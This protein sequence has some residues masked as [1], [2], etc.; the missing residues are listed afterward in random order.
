MWKSLIAS[1]AAVGVG[2]GL[3]AGQTP[4]CPDPSFPAIG[5][6]A[7]S[8]PP[9]AQPQPVDTK[10]A[11]E[12]PRSDP[13]GFNHAIF[14]TGP[15]PVVSQA[16]GQMAEPAPPPVPAAPSPFAPLPGLSTEEYV[17]G[18]S[19]LARPGTGRP[20]VWGSA[21]LLLGNTSGVNVAPVVT[22]GIPFS[23][24]GGGAMLGGLGT[25]PVFGGKKMLDN[26]RTGLKT[27]V[28]AWFDPGHIWGASARFYS[29]Y[30]TSDQF[31]AI[32]DGWTIINLPQRITVVTVGGTIYQFPIYVSSPALVPGD[33]PVTGAAA[34]T[35][36][37]TFTGGDLNLRRLILSN[38]QFRVELF[39]GY[40]QMH[41]GDELGAAFISR[42][43]PAAGFLT[44]EGEDSIR[45]RNNFYGTQVGGLGS[46]ALGRFTVQGTSSVALGVNASDLD[47][48]R[49]RI[50]R[51]DSVAIIA[52]RRIEG[53][54]VNYFS[55]AAEG[56]VR[57]GFRI[58]EH[59]KLTVGYT[60]IYWSNV[61]R[62]QE[63]YNLSPTL[64]GGTTHF[65]TNMLSLGAELKY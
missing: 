49:T 21:E 43:G 53:G 15:R 28:G 34:T 25:S 65:Y 18:S 30:S 58:A 42:R 40:R 62:A 44:I 59:A 22:T 9:P 7:P 33:E 3:A 45:T 17:W 19:P 24:G 51:T 41:L 52:E 57:V 50:A 27:E 47:Y 5:P 14:W 46:I 37:T 35:A 31:E 38:E 26:W 56:G 32:G 12:I 1:V 54:R 8:G 39:A 4:I 20:W 61:R 10:P 36:Q 11:P 6:L 63:Q 55:V 60:G 2:S 23:A 16:G 64:T 13:D 48:S 29:L